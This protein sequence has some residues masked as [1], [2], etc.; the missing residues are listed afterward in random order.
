[1]ARIC[2][3]TQQLKREIELSHAAKAARARQA[4][5]DIPDAKAAD[6]LA[7]LLAPAT[8]DDVERLRVRRDLIRRNDPSGLERLVGQRDIVSIISSPA[9]CRP[10]RPYAGSRRSAWPAVP[11]TMRAASWRPR[12]C[13]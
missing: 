9:A 5:I 4:P 1:M 8:K 7:S 11:R 2:D 12:H 13:S 6:R 10:P 3:A